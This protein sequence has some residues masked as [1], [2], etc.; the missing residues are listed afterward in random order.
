MRILGQKNKK[1]KKIKKISEK[2]LTRKMALISL[3]VLFDLWV[4]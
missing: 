4:L 2:H 3:V 1:I